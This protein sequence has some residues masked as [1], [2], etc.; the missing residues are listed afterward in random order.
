MN[1]KPKLQVTK[2]Y[3]IFQ[4]HPLN[5]D[6]AEKHALL[7]SMKTHGFMPSSPIHCVRTSSGLKV[8]RGHHRL[9]LAKRLKLPVWYV[10]DDSNTD[11]FDLEGDASQRW[12]VLDFAIGRA[13]NGDEHA[14]AVIAFQRKHH[15]TLGVAVSLLYGQGAGSGNAVGH[16]KRGTFEVAEDLRHARAVVGI[17]DH[18]RSCGIAFA[19][20]AAL[21]HAISRCLRVPEFKADVLKHRISQTPTIIKKRT[22]TEAYMD[23]LESA[24]NYAAKGRRLPLKFRAAEVGKELNVALKAQR[25]RL[26]TLRLSVGVVAPV[27]RV[28][29]QTTLPVS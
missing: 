17:T 25:K 12:S 8:I 26:K 22:N 19:T 15:L 23:E 10:I 14:K 13:K 9:D 16:L 21:V 4:M 1:D 7:A 27:R 2:D 18:L 3:S 24:Y 11:I 20:Q 28:S 5:R 6:I 29:A